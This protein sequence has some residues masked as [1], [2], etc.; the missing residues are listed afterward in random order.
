MQL[1][2]LKKYQLEVVSQYF[3]ARHVFFADQ[4]MAKYPKPYITL[5][6]HGY[7]RNMN[8]ITMFDESDQCNKD[9][10]ASKVDLTINLYSIGRNVS[11]AGRT[12]V[13]ENTTLEDMSDFI[14]Y[15]QSD[16]VADDIAEH[17][18]S[19]TDISNVEDL[20]SLEN[21]GSTF[22]YRSMV[23]L[24]LSFTEVSYGKYGQNAIPSI[25]NTSG[26]G[27]KEMVQDSD[28]IETINITGGLKR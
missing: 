12:P 17:N 13:Y 7:K 25:P 9:Y 22:Q 26:G 20:A 6:F 28:I 1:N 10:W 4:K 18:V 11:P 3:G 27:T 21:E 16:T 5:K 2:E 24:S 23:K 14:L 19:I 8:K 15:L